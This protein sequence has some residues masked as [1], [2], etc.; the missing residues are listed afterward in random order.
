MKYERLVISF[1]F[2]IEQQRT[3]DSVEPVIPVSHSG[4]IW[5]YLGH[6]WTLLHSSL[7]VLVCGS[8]SSLKVQFGQFCVYMFGV[9]SV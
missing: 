6:N 4:I 5:K 8:T 1:K 2:S 9:C 3:P 7:G